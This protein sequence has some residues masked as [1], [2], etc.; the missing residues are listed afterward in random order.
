MTDALT[1]FQIPRI[2]IQL[3]LLHR[4]ACCFDR[5][6]FLCLF[7]FR[8]T[9]VQTDRQ[10]TP[11][12]QS[13]QHRLRL[14][15]S[16]LR[17]PER[18]HPLRHAVAHRKCLH[19]VLLKFLPKRTLRIQNFFF[20]PCN[21]TQYTV[22]KTGQPLKA[23]FLCQTHG[24]VACRRIRHGVHIQN[25]IDRQAQQTADQRFHFVR[26]RFGIRVDDIVQRQETFQRSFR[27]T[28]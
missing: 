4:H 13:L 27:Q 11:F 26:R 23:L 21:C 17:F 8:Q 2:C 10:R 24:F 1:A 6:D 5:C 22:Y 18:N 16:I 14:F 12:F 7:F 3:V 28:F 20:V 25:L 9:A 19:R 15:F